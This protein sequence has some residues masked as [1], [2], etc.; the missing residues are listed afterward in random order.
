MQL[1]TAYWRQDPL[2]G[3][4]TTFPFPGFPQDIR[5]AQPILERF[6][7]A[8]LQ[9]VAGSNPVRTKTYNILSD[10][11]FQNQ[12]W[13]KATCMAGVLCR[14]Y[15]NTLGNR[16]ARDALTRRAAKDAADFMT[17]QVFEGSP[18]FNNQNCPADIRN[19]FGNFKHYIT[20]IMQQIQGATTGS[21]WGQQQ[22]SWGGQTNG[23]NQPKKD[24]TL[25]MFNGQTNGSEQIFRRVNDD[26]MGG[27]G[28]AMMDAIIERDQMLEKQRIER[29]QRNAQESAA[30]FS[31]GTH[32]L[33]D[34]Y[35]AGPEG[36]SLTTSAKAEFADHFVS[37]P[38]LDWMSGGSNTAVDT[39]TVVEPQYIMQA[40]A[41]VEVEQELVGSDFTRAFHPGWD[42]SLG[43]PPYMPYVHEDTPVPRA[44]LPVPVHPAYCG[45]IRVYHNYYT[46]TVMSGWVYNNKDLNKM[47]P[48]LHQLRYDL[49]EQPKPEGLVIPIYE[50]NKD[51]VGVDQEF[52]KELPLKLHNAVAGLELDIAANA[53]KQIYNVDQAMRPVHFTYMNTRAVQVP[54]INLEEA[55]AAFTWTG[56]HANSDLTVL[57]QAIIGLR[58]SSEFMAAKMDVFATETINRIMR[59]EL[60]TSLRIDSFVEDYAELVQVLREQHGDKHIAALGRCSSMIARVICC[61]C[62]PEYEERLYY[63]T[64]TP[65]TALC[66]GFVSK[67]DGLDYCDKEAFEE[68]QEELRDEDHPTTRAYGNY[69]G[70]IRLGYVAV[71]PWTLEEMGIDLELDARVLF[72]STSEYHSYFTQVLEESQ[73]GAPVNRVTVITTDYQAVDLHYLE[74]GTKG[75]IV[76]ERRNVVG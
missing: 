61:V 5:D 69:V 11:N 51:D 13:Q 16:E 18:E 44:D 19:G 36:G 66:S 45:N 72:P 12:N 47:D 67:P 7:R 41:P 60:N 48:S 15:M 42:L 70:L 73:A 14:Y 65:F 1:N 10:Q 6:I 28:N 76:V 23:W 57:A 63:T 37:S 59:N 64:V 21:G 74:V 54:D 22:N 43:K 9:E 30:M 25:D 4:E 31:T 8:Y 27:T 50:L 62:P 17:L 38:D 46:Q 55:F 52:V 29:E 24:T 75:A 32:D 53:V 49:R 58:S 39:K 33:Y 34:E 20:Q 56:R 35:N 71:V 68:A 2:N 40:A 26:P 3:Q